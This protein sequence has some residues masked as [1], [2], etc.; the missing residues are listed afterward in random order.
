MSLQVWLP[1]NG[2]FNNQ[3]LD[4]FLNF[5]T[6]GTVSDAEGKIGQSK[7]FSSSNIIAPYDF[8]LG[9]EASICLWVYYTAFPSSSS[10]DWIICYQT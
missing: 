4:G 10:N 9:N 8:T 6:T 1:L 7:L 5:T 3:G 2:N